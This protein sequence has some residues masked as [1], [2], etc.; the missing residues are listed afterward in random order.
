M[1]DSIWFE[2]ALR[3]LTYLVIVAVVGVLVALAH[4]VDT[5]FDTV[6]AVH[7]DSAALQLTDHSITAA[8]AVGSLSASADTTESAP[9]TDTSTTSVS[10]T[11]TSTTEEPVAEQQVSEVS[12]PEKVTSFTLAD[13]AE[14]RVPAEDFNAFWDEVLAGIADSEC[15]VSAPGTTVVTLT[16]GAT[17]PEHL[18]DAY[19]DYAPLI[20][21]ARA[22][23]AERCA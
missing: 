8:P 2:A 21:A 18:G 3:S 4:P 20:E 13:V 6:P 16:I 23:V 14:G 10:A 22:E 9:D 1:H 5:T 12:D 17:P 11:D 19:T 7:V 15:V